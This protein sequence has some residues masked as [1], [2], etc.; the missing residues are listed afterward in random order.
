MALLDLVEGVDLAIIID[1]VVGPPPG[2]IQVLELERISRELPA[3][4]SSHGIGVGQIVALAR[5]VLAKPPRAVKF[6][7]VGIEQPRRY[8]AALS[9]AVR[10]AVEPAA[11]AVLHL[12][13]SD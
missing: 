8:E 3:G 7:A 2:S 9:P 11:D 10:A 6:V 1:A 5:E 12:T 13:S 4:F